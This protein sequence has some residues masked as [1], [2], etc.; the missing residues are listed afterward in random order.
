MDFEWLELQQRLIPLVNYENEYETINLLFHEPLSHK[1]VCKSAQE[2]LQSLNQDENDEFS[3]KAMQVRIKEA[4]DLRKEGNDLMQEKGNPSKVL[5][6]CRLYTDAIFTAIGTDSVELSLG[7]ANRALALQSFGYYQQ[8]YDDCEC[9]LETGYPKKLHQ[10][11]AAFVPIGNQICNNCAKTN[12]IPIPCQH[13]RGRVVY[14]SLA[15]LKNHKNIH[16]Y[17]CPAYHL[18]LFARVGIAHLALRTIL[19]NGLLTI[20]NLLQDKHTTEDV[21]T[22]LV[23]GGDVWSNPTATYSES[24]RMVSHLNKMTLEDIKVF[25]AVSH[26]I[27]VYLSRYTKFF[28]FLTSNHRFDCNWELIVTALILKHIGQLMVNGHVLTV[29]RPKLF[30]YYTLTEYHLLDENLWEKPWHLKRGYLHRFS[31]ID[32][33]ASLNLPYTSICNHSCLPLFQPKFSGRIISTF[34]MRDIQKG[35][36]ITNCYTRHYRIERRQARQE[37][38]TKSYHFVCKCVEC[39]R[40]EGDEY[41]NQFHQYRCDNEKCRHVFVPQPPLNWWQD[42]G[43]NGLEDTNVSC[44]VC[45][46]QQA[47]KW[48]YDYQNMLISLDSPLT[49]LRLYKLYQNLDEYLLAFNS[50]RAFIASKSVQQ[51]FKFLNDGSLDEV[52]YGNLA[53]MIKYALEYEAATSGFR[54][55]SYV[56]EMTYLW[57]LIALGKCKCEPEDMNSMSESLMIVDDELSAIFSNYYKDYILKQ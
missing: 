21:W 47:F 1:L 46:S 4:A 18:Q 34:A 7:F 39:I 32:D 26:L 23:E 6:A 48:F 9:A 33:M 54:C 27:V 30:E 52:D 19:D 44:N 28:D 38:L 13:C 3:S 11:A 22:S 15:C 55:I 40:P 12:F 42:K 35:E 56:S 14:C 10:R 53:R 45:G 51:I 41:I 25:A 36:E 43:S 5:A 31:F 8:A 2:W 49:R 16:V 50:C 37:I 57:D 20:L 24:L 29:I 17:E